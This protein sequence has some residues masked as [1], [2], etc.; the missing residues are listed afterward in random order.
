MEINQQIINNRNPN[1]IDIENDERG[2][3]F[4]VNK[5]YQEKNF[6]VALKYLIKLTTIF[7]NKAEYFSGMAII[8]KIMG[9]YVEAEE[10]YKKSIEIDPGLYEGYYN[11]GILVY[12][13][14][15]INEAV[16][17]FLKAINIKPDLYL[18]YYN[19]GNAYRELNELTLSINS[20]KKT[21]DLKKDFDDVH[22]N[23][24]VVFEKKRELANAIKCYETA[25]L[26]NP[27]NLNARWN[28]ALLYLQSGD[29]SKGWVRF[30]VRKDR[31]KSSKRILNKPELKTESVNGRK[32]LIYCE[33]GL[34]DTIQF[35]RYLKIL[36]DHGAYVIF[37]CKP[38]LSGIF[39]D[40]V[41]IDELILEQ[42]NKENNIEY[43][44]HISLLS[45]PLYFNTT[46][47]T[48]P[49]TVPYLKANQEKVNEWKIIVKNEKYINIGIAWSGSEGNLTGKDRSCKLDDFTPLFALKGIRL[50]SL[51]KAENNNQLCDGYPVINFNNMDLI[52]FLDTA[53]IIENLDLVISI[54]TSIAHLAGALG[55]PVWT[56]LPYYS[57]WRWLL[58]RESSPWYPT[59][60]LFRQPEPGQWSKGFSNV[61]VEIKRALNLKDQNLG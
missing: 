49:S 47:D 16:T 56:L 1:P 28:L 34:G 25:I 39:K 17:Y 13:Q 41:G 27:N 38:R 61:A 7:P 42:N 3:L 9:N 43:E 40:F 5:N 10:N 36:K 53:A 12:E 37:E 11:L 33:Q 22:Y 44:Y 60:R 29:F 18:A 48:I 31:I 32:I 59:M 15:R 55:K 26:F 51:Q 54:D 45:L 46:L 30:E 6:T 20:Y 8:Q 35:S 58:N 52:P 21:I 4:L 2:L 24:G 19:L 23:L 57:D 50:F 14:N